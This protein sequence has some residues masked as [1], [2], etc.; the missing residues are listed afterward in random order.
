LLLVWFRAITRITKLNKTTRNLP[1]E[2][3]DI[4]EY[5]QDVG[6]SD[7]VVAGPWLR[8]FLIT[9]KVP[10]I[11]P[12]EILL[13]VPHPSTLIGREWRLGDSN[14]ENLDILADLI[15]GAV[16]DADFTYKSFSTKTPDG[17]TGG[18]TSLYKLCFQTGTHHPKETITVQFRKVERAPFYYVQSYYFGINRCMFDGEKYRL[19][20][21]CVRDAGDKTITIKRRD[22][23]SHLADV[24]YD[25]QLMRRSAYAP[26]TLVILD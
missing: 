4:L 17:T 11:T 21:E 5:S 16:V 15:E 7:A 20:P 26:Y 22:Y 12:C 18:G 25:I 24:K 13:Y 23:Q 9:G 3:L 2:I 1:P 19:F 10:T 14:R 6:Y 8:D